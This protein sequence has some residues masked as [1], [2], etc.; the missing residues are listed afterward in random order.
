MLSSWWLKSSVF[1][2]PTGKLSAPGSR[3]RKRHLADYFC[4]AHSL[5]WCVTCSQCY[6]NGCETWTYS[7]AIDHKINAFEMFCYR[8]M[9]RI[10]W[11]SHTTDIDVLQKIG[12]KETTML[13]TLKNRKLSYAV[14]EAHGA[15]AAITNWH[16]CHCC[17]CSWVCFLLAFSCSFVPIDIK[18]QTRH[19]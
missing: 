19:Y 15:L 13:N 18:D 3:E 16:V 4:S 12:V 14:S 7:I 2:A 9:L 6:H 5:L 11:T 1:H 10:S 17:Q 8:R